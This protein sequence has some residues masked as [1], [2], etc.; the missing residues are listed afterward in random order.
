VKTTIRSAEPRPI[1]QRALARGR[2]REL[3]LAQEA[4]AMVACGAT[5]RVVIAGI[6]HG[7]DILDSAR[8]IGLESGVRVNPLRQLDNDAADLVIEPIY[9]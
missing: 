2:E 1:S 5:R 8:R 9:D 6:R 7:D 4:I 3:R